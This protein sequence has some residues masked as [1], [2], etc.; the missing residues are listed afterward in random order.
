MRHRMRERRRPVDVGRLEP[1]GL[2]H[3]DRDGIDGN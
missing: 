1:R 2:H 3:R